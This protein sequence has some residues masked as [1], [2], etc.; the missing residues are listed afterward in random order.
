M[1]QLLKDK[2]KATIFQILVEIANGQPNIQQKDIA[3]KLDITPQAVSEYIGQLISGNMLISQG[4]SSYRITKD[5]VSWIIEMLRELATYNN[6]VKNAINNISICTAIAESNLEKDQKVGLKMKEGILMAS[7]D[8]SLPAKG[9]AT[10]SARTGDDVGITNIEGIVQLTLGKATILRIP[11]IE[12]GG[13]RSIDSRIVK[14]F[15]KKSPFIGAIGLE[16]FALLNR[17]GIAFHQ[18]GIIEAAI[19]A[20]KSGVDTSILCVENETSP[21]L[22]RFEEENIPYELV[23]TWMV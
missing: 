14:K 21:I 3:D 11:G 6:Y 12:K 19:E 2:R 15:I 7:S 4:R 10:S 13:S 16:S 20:V 8:I 18:Y 17:L 23:D 9:I 5:G 1:S 22:S